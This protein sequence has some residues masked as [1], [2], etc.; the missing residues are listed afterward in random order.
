MLNAS[1]RGEQFLTKPESHLLEP[2]FVTCSVAGLPE[3]FVPAHKDELLCAR[4]VSDP[5]RRRPQLH[6][7][8]VQWIHGGD[9]G[10]Y[11]GCH[12]G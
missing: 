2:R 11:G 10:R 4:G 12:F 3:T 5:Q 9:Q 1:D 6:I 7:L 8:F